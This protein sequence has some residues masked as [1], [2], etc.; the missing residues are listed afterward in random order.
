[1]S[2]HFSG[3]VHAEGGLTGSGLQAPGGRTFYVNTNSA[4]AA[5]NQ[6]RPWFDV[7]GVTV[8]STLQDAIDACVASR[9]DIIYIARG[10]ETVTE[11][12]NFNKTGITVMVQSFGGP[13]HVMGEYT[14]LLAD[15]TFTDG[16][17]A[18]ITA[19]CTI[20]GLGFAGRDTG[21]TFY[22][23]AAC[24]IGG[25]ATASPYGVHMLD[26]RFP[27]WGL[28]NRMG[29]AI[30]GSSD[31]L[32]EHC[33]FEGVGTAFETGIYVQGA[34][35]NLQI[36]NNYFRDCTYAVTFGA[37]AGGGPH[38]ML[39]PGNVCED[40][41]LLDSGGNAATGVV[42]GNYLETATNASSYDDTVATLQ[43]QGIQFSGN[44]YSE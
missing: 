32:I 41:K 18:T 40:S 38:I 26:C 24:L 29:L 8:F 15:S 31:C 11:T 28:D 35:Q 37:F 3:Q 9:G 7:D 6:D 2:T 10:T 44:H 14:A 34:C 13:R 22:S 30:E 19:P 1:M 17:V 42:C 27:K 43:G 33:S 5:R 21:A 36:K 25:L 12:V 23:G 39:G 16:P 20:I 4:S